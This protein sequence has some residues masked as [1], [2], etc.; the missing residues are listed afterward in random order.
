MSALF[1]ANVT[2]MGVAASVALGLAIIL[3]WRL[4]RRNEALRADMDRLKRE[5]G[6]ATA[7]LR[8]RISEIARQ[9][10]SVHE[11]VPP[12][13]SRF[14]EHIPALET[15]VEGAEKQLSAVERQLKAAAEGVQTARK[16]TDKVQSIVT[17]REA[18]L[19]ELRE[20]ITLLRGTV[21]EHLARRGADLDAEEAQAGAATAVIAKPAATKK[22][23]TKVVSKPSPKAAKA[24]KQASAKGAAEPKAKSAAASGED[25]ADISGARWI[26]VVMAALLGAAL[27][28]QWIRTQ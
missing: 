8:S 26:F 25:G 24:P 17:K 22:A 27:L 4:N 21:D 12:L 1:L 2:L 3:F 16:E 13:V 19:S 14:K 15:R 5:H 9:V 23:K 11:E 28:A 6:E 7:D 18:S 10:D 20:A